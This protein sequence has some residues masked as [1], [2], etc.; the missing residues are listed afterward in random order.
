M[1]TDTVIKSEGMN[2][3]IKNLGLVDAERFIM[4]MNRE[5]FDYTA[6]RDSGLSSD[7]TVRELSRIAME[8]VG[9]Q[10]KE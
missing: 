2:A 4:L 9:Q 1:K 6:W 3:L 8:Q 7:L 10:K 5:P